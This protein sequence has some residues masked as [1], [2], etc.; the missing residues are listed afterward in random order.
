MVHYKDLV[1]GKSYVLGDV[2]VGEFTGRDKEDEAL[3]FFKGAE[4]ADPEDGDDAEIDAHDD[5]EFREVSARRMGKRMRKRMGR[6]KRKRAKKQGS[7]TR[8]RSRSR[9]Q[10]K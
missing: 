10:S 9:S 3:L 6:T 1:I 5:D 2:R 4:G 7:Q 8:S